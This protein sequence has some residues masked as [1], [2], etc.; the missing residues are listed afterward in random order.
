MP[1]C[2]GNKLKVRSQEAFGVIRS[3]IKEIKNSQEK[4][5]E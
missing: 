1:E 4:K 2:D 5:G 3:C